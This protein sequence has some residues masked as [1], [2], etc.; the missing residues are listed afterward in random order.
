MTPRKGQDLREKGSHSR[1]SPS[2]VC[3]VIPLHDF[4]HRNL[5]RETATPPH[6]APSPLAT[7]IDHKRQFDCASATQ[8]SL[9]A[10]DDRRLSRGEQSQLHNREMRAPGRKIHRG[11]GSWKTFRCVIRRLSERILESA[12]ASKLWKAATIESIEK[13]GKQEALEARGGGDE[14]ERRM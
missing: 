10:P 9:R 2:C 14:G 11:D 4:R 8:H 1:A 12:L 6:T 3:V 7:H 5:D 13:A